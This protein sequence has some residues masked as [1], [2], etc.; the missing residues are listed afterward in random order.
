[1]SFLN[2]AWK[3]RTAKSQPPRSTPTRKL[4]A[5]KAPKKRRMKGRKNATLE[6]YIAARAKTGNPVLRPGDAGYVEYDDE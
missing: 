6:A 2:K 4:R 5:K 1:V 3:M